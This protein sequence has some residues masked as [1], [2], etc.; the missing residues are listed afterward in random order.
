VLRR[1]QEWDFIIVGG[2][3][4]GCVLAHR[5]SADAGNRVLLLEAGGRDWSPYIHVPAAIIKAVGNPALDWCHLA[6]P[7]DTRGGKVDLWPA[8]KVLG[9]SSSINGMLFVRGHP[10]DFDAWAALGNHGWSFADVLPYFKRLERTSFGDDVYR[11]RD[12]PLNVEPLRTRHPLADVFIAALQESGIA[13]N[14]DYNGFDN[15]GVGVPQVTQR[16]GARCSASRAFLWPISGRRNLQ[17]MTGACAERLLFEQRRCVGVQLRHRDEISEARARREVILAAGTLGSPKL[18]LLSGLGPARQLCDHGIPLVADLPAVGENL[19]EHP[20]GMVSVD[21][22]VPTYNTEVNSWNIVKHMASW[23]LVRRGPAT[24]P[25]PHAV[26]FI[27]SCRE[28]PR[29][30]VQVLFGP[31]AFA[32]TEAGIAPYLKPAV[33]A[34]LNPTHPSNPGRLRLRSRDPADHPI[35]E[36]RL[37]ASSDDV[38]ALIAACRLMRQAFRNPAFRPYVVQER[39][40]G[41]EVERDDE[42][43]EYLRRVAFLGYHPVGTCRMGVDERAVV[44]PQ[45]RVRGVTDLRVADASVMP[46]LISANTNAATMMIGERAA[47]LVLG[48]AAA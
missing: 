26:A 15:E 30:D 13:L 44:D 43:A 28:K 16:R 6:E 25:Y 20:N 21:V 4:A 36:H 22:N 7:D 9:G 39:L 37:L 2:G 23:L 8:G 17:I 35:I 32:L 12:G 42:W 29:P 40:P 3:S 31:Y 38:A 10:Q 27:R 33:T 48:K 47:D 14:A 41:P 34:V 18:L 24:S 1:A 45:L 5:L 11:G 46:T 19:L